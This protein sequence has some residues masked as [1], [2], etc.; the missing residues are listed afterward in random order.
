MLLPLIADG[1]VMKADGVTPFIQATG[2]YVHVTGGSESPSCY[3]AS[4][5]NWGFSDTTNNWPTGN[6]VATTDIISYRGKTYQ[7]SVTFYHVE[8]EPTQPVNIPCYEIAQ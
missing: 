7:G 8:G 3:I 4:N 2:Y 6:Y 5:A 1:K